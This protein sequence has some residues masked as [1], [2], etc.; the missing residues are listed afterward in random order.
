MPA[1]RGTVRDCV[2][3][4]RCAAT[5]D[6][7]SRPLRCARCAQGY[8]TV[9]PIPVILPRF[10]EH[11]TL[12]QRQLSALKAQAEHTLSAIE[13]EL[14]TPGLLPAGVERLRALGQ[15]LR[16]QVADIA[17]VVGP[18]LGEAEPGGDAGLPRGIVEYI[19]F[20]Y[21][22]WGWESA[23]NRENE[24]AFAALQQVLSAGALG[25]TL[26]LG[27]GACR[28]AYDVHRACGATETAV[29]DIDPYLLLIAEA[30]IRGQTVRLTEA[31]ANVQ[32]LSQIFKAWQL[33]APQGPLDASQFHFFLAN[34]L[35]PPFA[36]H[37]FDTVITPWFIDQVPQD[38]AAFIAVLKRQL[39]SGGRW[40][41]SGPLLYPADTPLARRW[42]REEVFDLAEQAG[43]HITRWWSESRNH[44]A[45]PLN[46]RAKVEW[47]LTFEALAPRESE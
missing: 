24:R 37:S 5:L 32:E 36:D 33:R 16:D 27:A 26:V 34:G 29:L 43:F 44:L 40:L 20:L 17:A 47:L 22:D 12:W 28:L 46:G 3:C 23:G 31:T 7:A 25:R 6:L 42:S 9:G 39:R 4:V 38:L 21:R 19:Q 41:N 14:S 13:G 8:G 45:S 1:E 35:A 18:A 10:D 2:V 30:V 15:A 11:L